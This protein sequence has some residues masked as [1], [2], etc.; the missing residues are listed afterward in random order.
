LIFGKLSD[1]VGRK[2]V[3]TFAMLCYSGALAL[4]WFIKVYNHHTYLWYIAAVGLGLGDSTFNTQIY[5]TLGSVFGVKDTVAA[6]TVFQLLQNI[7]SAIGFFYSP[8]LPV[9][10]PHGTFYQLIILG[11]IGWLG[12]FLFWTIDIPKGKSRSI[13]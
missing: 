12:T 4:S 7:G 9:H 3:L 1:I 10:G 2:I 8:Y 13:H 5:A 6:F 11:V